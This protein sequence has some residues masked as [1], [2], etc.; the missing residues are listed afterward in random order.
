MSV[1]RKVTAHRFPGNSAAPMATPAGIPANAAKS[2]DQRETATEVRTAATTSASR[3]AMRVRAA[4]S[5]AARKSMKLFP[6]D[7]EDRFAVGLIAGDD[8]LPLG[9]GDVLD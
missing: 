9:A 2:V 8:P 5:E 7:E 1:L 4:R 3:E 6:V